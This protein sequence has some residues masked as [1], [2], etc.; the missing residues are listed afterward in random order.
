MISKTRSGAGKEQ[1]Y[2]VCPWIDACMSSTTCMWYVQKKHASLLRM[3]SFS[4][5]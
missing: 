2:R 4:K 1:N 5:N 3:V